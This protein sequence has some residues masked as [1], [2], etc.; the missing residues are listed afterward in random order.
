MDPSAMDR[1]RAVPVSWN[2][3]P[4]RGCGLIIVLAL[5]AWAAVILLALVIWRAV[6]GRPLW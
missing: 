2:G 5:A 1:A 4:E 6:G 3:D